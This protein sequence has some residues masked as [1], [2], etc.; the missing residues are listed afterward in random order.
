MYNT[1]KKYQPITQFLL[2]FKTKM[3]KIT[4]ILTKC[5]VGGRGQ[6]EG[7][8]EG[9]GGQTGEGAEEILNERSGLI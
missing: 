1:K 9:R 8:R 3:Y 7:G 2:I 4:L 5:K 6:E